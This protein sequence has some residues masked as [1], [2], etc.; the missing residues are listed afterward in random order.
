MIPVYL[1]G[2]AV[3][4]VGVPDIRAFLRLEHEEEDV[5]LGALIKAARLVV[6][7]TTRLVLV[8]QRWRLMLA[9]PPADGVVRMPLA[10]ILAVTEVRAFDI[11]D[12]ASVVPPA[13]WTLERRADPVRLVLRGAAATAEGGLEIDLDVGYGAGIADVPAPLVQAI[14]L[15]VAHWFEN[16]GDA[17]ASDQPG[18]P[19]DVAAL[20]APF[21]RLRMG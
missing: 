13:D 2:P 6:E 4:P 12:V 16:R 9:A 19:P 17:L 21:R 10:P 14:R 7:A 15:L 11:G 1:D 18:L 20:I 8:E 3:E 5:L